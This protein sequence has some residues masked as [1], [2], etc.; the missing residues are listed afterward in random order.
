MFS[1]FS[2]F[3]NFY[4]NFS[5]SAFYG[6]MVCMHFLPW[7]FGTKEECSE[8]SHLFE[9]DMHGDEFYRVSLEAGGDKADE[10]IMEIVRHSSRMG[11]M[12][13]F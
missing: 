13:H 10:K 8:L 4:K 1:S 5:K 7:M 2:S 11:Y 12:D 3:E 9:T 6:V